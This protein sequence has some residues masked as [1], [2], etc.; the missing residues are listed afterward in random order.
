MYFDPGEA[1]ELVA[2]RSEILRYRSTALMNDRE[3]AEFLGLPEGCRMREN[4]KILN[5]QSFVC[6]TYVW[7]VDEAANTVSQR[8]VTTGELDRSGIQIRDGLDPGEL[9]VV[10]GASFL[11]DGQVVRPVELGS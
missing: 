4:A 1:E 2:I 7:I 3:R 9:V 6:G 10:S 11:T 8:S 5:P